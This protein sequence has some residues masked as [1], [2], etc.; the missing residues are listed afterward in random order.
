MGIESLHSMLAAR[1][2]LAPA[3]AMPAAKPEADFG[4]VLEHYLQRMN[5]EHKAAEKV[6]LDLALGR[7]QNTAETLLA[8]Q[9]AELSF[10]L[11][12][13]VRN[14]LVDAYHEIMRMQV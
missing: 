10:Q 5:R 11:M 1:S 7:S 6:G 4:Q 8:I 2:A 3:D 14:K 12:M 9:K 13:S